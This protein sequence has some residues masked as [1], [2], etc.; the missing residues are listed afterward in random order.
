LRSE[1][2]E[3]VAKDQRT[4]EPPLTQPSPCPSG[5]WLSGG[6]AIIDVTGKISNAND[7]LAVWLG[8]TPAELIG[9]TLPRLVAQHD[10]AWEKLIADFLNRPISFD[11]LNLQSKGRQSQGLC[12]EVAR[13]GDAT[14]VRLESTLPSTAELEQALPAESWGKLIAHQSF[15]RL[16]RA[17]TQ[18]DNLQ[19]RWPG[20][21]F[22]QRPDFS[23]SFVSPK[24][25][26]LTGVP[27]SEWRRQSRGFWQII[28]EADA[29]ELQHR[30]AACSESSE[31]LTSTYRIRH[32]HTGRVRYLWEH[33]RT[34]HSV[35]GLLL[36][37]EGI[38]LDITRQSLAERRLVN[39]SWKES[40]GTLTM[41]LAHDF[42]NVLTGVV[43]L[44]DTFETE[45]AGSES[46]RSGLAIM[47]STAGQAVDLAR[48]IRQLHHGVAGQKNYHDLNEIIS[49]I[50]P[51]LQKVLTRRVKIQIEPSTEQLPIYVDAVELQQVIVNLAF[52]AVDAMPN[53]GTLMFITSRAE[54]SPIEPVLEGKMPR[55]P[56][57][58]LSVRD[59]GNGIPE[60]YLNSIFEPFFTTKPL[61]K[62]SGLG[63]YNARLFTESHEVAISVETK[64]QTGTTVHL[65]FAQSDFSEAEA[66]K[67]HDATTR[68]AILVFCE[69]AK[70]PDP[71]SNLLRENGFYVMTTHS[72]AA[73]IEALH[74]AEYH[75]DALLLIGN[76]SALASLPRRIRAANLP[77]KL[78]FLCN[79]DEALAQPCQTQDNIDL[80]F[81]ADLP[82]GDF[83]QR[84]K[85][86]LDHP[87]TMS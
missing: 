86:G 78:F 43:S 76:E 24:I 81:Q 77:I 49:G 54:Q 10:S 11:R 16:L 58:R 13:Q 69:S 48:K 2:Q 64:E 80:R 4:G 73:A 28:H 79:Q 70:N 37:Y 27:V 5:I 44:S 14:F 84:L 47:R 83:L 8:A 72:E 21:I 63:L 6:I 75:F 29:E 39:M 74:S 38:W 57:V 26:E 34:I 33:R 25:E 87:P 30:L 20:L 45:F 35:N 50:A 42:C 18:L 56:F 7:S 61:G 36:G 62:G 15:H 82:P 65:W 55:A 52:N 40:L 85:A 3:S 12:I 32:A 41:G 60:Q 53:G 51:V 22:S 71:T 68:R 1:T 23:F 31:G 46:A 9:Q 66:T 17:E 59:T 19:Q 67:N